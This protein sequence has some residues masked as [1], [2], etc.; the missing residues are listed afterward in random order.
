MF[1]YSTELSHFFNFS[2]A[3]SCGVKRQAPSK[4]KASKR[5]Y[6]GKES[7]PGEWPW[8]ASVQTKR[9]TKSP[10]ICGGAIL[11]KNFIL[12]AAHCFSK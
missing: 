1:D 11:S 3:L 10:K 12:T 6:G 2:G 9:G 8:M 4:K 5:V 7:Q